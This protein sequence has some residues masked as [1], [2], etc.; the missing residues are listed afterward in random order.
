MAQLLDRPS[1]SA[2]WTWKGKTHQRRYT[3]VYVLGGETS[4][5][6]AAYL[7]AFGRLPEGR[8]VHR[9]ECKA[10]IRCANV[11]HYVERAKKKGSPGLSSTSASDAAAGLQLGGLFSLAPRDEATQ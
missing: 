2:C 6:V 3:R 11:L 10:G 5:P 9:K 8:L 1:P 7:L 4:L